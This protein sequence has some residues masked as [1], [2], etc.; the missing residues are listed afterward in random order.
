[1]VAVIAACIF[2]S[3]KSSAD[4]AGKAATAGM[5]FIVTFFSSILRKR[6]FFRAELTAALDDEDRLIG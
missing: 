1:M 3:T 6:I 2:R 5:C 4:L